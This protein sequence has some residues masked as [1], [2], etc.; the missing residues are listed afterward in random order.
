[1]SLFSFKTKSFYDNISVNIGV[2]DSIYNLPFKMYNY[3]KGLCNK[4]EK[5]ERSI[6]FE[7]PNKYESN[8]LDTDKSQSQICLGHLNPAI[9]TTKLSSLKG[10]K[11]DLFSLINEDDKKNNS[12]REKKII[13]R[14]DRNDTNS[15]ILENKI[16]TQ[17]HHSKS[18]LENKREKNLV[19]PD[20]SNMNKLIK[21]KRERNET[22]NLNEENQ[23]DASNKQIKNDKKSEFYI[24]IPLKFKPA[25]FEEYREEEMK[26][27]NTNRDKKLDINE[28]KRALS[29]LKER[30]RTEIDSFDKLVYK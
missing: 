22:E 14:K 30:Q 28:N 10:F 18:W 24:R 5:I 8:I 15:F 20:F 9:I 4:P 16:S 6:S 7:T 3:I 25:C 2:V 11:R 23:K 13:K 12:K 21:R 17:K 26:E 29:N 1:M 19:I 27:S